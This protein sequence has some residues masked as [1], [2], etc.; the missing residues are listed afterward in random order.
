M[1]PLVAC[2]ARVDE[3][4]WDD[5]TGLEACPTDPATTT[6]PLSLDACRLLL[7]ASDSFTPRNLTIHCRDGKVI[8]YAPSCPKVD[9]LCHPLLWSHVHLR[10]RRALPLPEGQLLT[11]WPSSPNRAVAGSRPAPLRQR[12]VDLRGE[13][14]VPPVG[15][16][17]TRVLTPR[18]TRRRLGRAVGFSVFSVS[19][20]SGS[21]GA[22]RDGDLARRAR[23]S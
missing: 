4:R 3:P 21:A 8:G 18:A 23:V 20:A 2:G 1:S 11:T 19:C 9:R 12:A 10:I 13:E 17:R 14:R 5:M 16:V 7:D 15:G 6:C 22:S